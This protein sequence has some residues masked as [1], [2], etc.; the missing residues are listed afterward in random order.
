MFSIEY[1][2]SRGYLCKQETIKGQGYLGGDGVTCYRV[3]SSEGQLAVYAISTHR[4]ARAAWRE[5][6]ELVKS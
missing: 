4:T 2:K 5:A 1:L 3:R 6:R